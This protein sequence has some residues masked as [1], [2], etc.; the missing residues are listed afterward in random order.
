MAKTTKGND[1]LSTITQLL[2]NL[3]AI[4]LWRGSLSQE[5]IGK[6]LGVAKGSAN[7]MLKGVSRVIASGTGNEG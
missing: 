7:K 6:R 3:L 4:E 2:R 5:E 1:D